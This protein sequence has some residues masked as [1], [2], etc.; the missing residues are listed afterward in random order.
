MRMG[1][2]ASVFS[3][4]VEISSCDVKQCTVRTK[5][6]VPFTGEYLTVELTLADFGEAVVTLA[7]AEDDGFFDARGTSAGN[8]IDSVELNNLVLNKG[9]TKITRELS[10]YVLNVLNTKAT[11]LGNT[12]IVQLYQNKSN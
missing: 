1:I 8:K 3:N 9:A 2:L 7:Y 5:E 4:E 6:I 12:A 11:E 10:D